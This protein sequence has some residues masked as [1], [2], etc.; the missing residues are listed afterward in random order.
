MLDK[1]I[2][3]HFLLSLISA[4]VAAA[5]ALTACD[6]LT[7]GHETGILLES[8]E[9]RQICH[10]RT[11]NVLIMVNISPQWTLSMNVQAGTQHARHRT[12]HNH[13][14]DLLL[15]GIQRSPA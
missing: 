10:P 3:Q 9:R 11:S 6:T 8:L 15:N 4:P 12:G 13:K 1:Y 5:K 14:A 7:V 2:S